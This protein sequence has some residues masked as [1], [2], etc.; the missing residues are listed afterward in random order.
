MDDTNPMRTPGPTPTTPGNRNESSPNRS[1]NY[2]QDNPLFRQTQGVTSPTWRNA[3]QEH[4][5]SPSRRSERIFPISSV[6]Q[7]PLTPGLRETDP[8]MTASGGRSA[9]SS[10]PYVEHGNPFDGERLYLNF[11][12][13]LDRQRL[14][15]ETRAARFASAF[16]PPV[17]EKTGVLQHPMTM[18]FQHKE[19]EEG[20][21]VVTVYVLSP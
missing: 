11:N 20:H 12:E 10:T 16:D 17:A 18:R 21:C 19:T 1:P 13:E 9:S 15:N 4:S 6:V 5:E 8:L 7:P 3:N 2:G 14:N